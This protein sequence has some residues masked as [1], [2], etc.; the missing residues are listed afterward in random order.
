[1]VFITLRGTFSMVLLLLP[2]CVVTLSSYVPS[3]RSAGMMNVSFEGSFVTQRSSATLVSF[4]ELLFRVI[5]TDGSVPTTF[6]LPPV[7]VK[8]RPAVAEASCARVEASCTPPMYMAL[9]F[10]PMMPTVVSLI[11][12]RRSAPT[13]KFTTMEFFAGFQVEFSM[14]PRKATEA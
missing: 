13:L 8:A 2:N 1:M 9:P 12:S 7:R 14:T 5:P 11:A 6:S 10:S 3:A 4:P